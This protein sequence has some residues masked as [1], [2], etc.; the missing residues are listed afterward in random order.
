MSTEHVIENPEVDELGSAGPKRRIKKKGARHSLGWEILDNENIKAEDGWEAQRENYWTSKICKKY[1]KMYHIGKLWPR[2]CHESH[3]KAFACKPWMCKNDHF[4]HRAE[5]VWQALFGNRPKSKGYFNYILLSMVYSEVV[6]ER[7]VDWT[8]FQTTAEFPLRIGRNQ[9]HIPDLFDPDSVLTKTMLEELKKVPRRVRA[10]DTVSKEEARTEDGGNHVATK[11]VSREQSPARDLGGC[12]LSEHSVEEANAVL[13]EGGGVDNV[14]DKIESTMIPVDSVVS[15]PPTS[16]NLE[17]KAK[18]VGPST[19]MGTA[20]E[21]KSTERTSPVAPE[22]LFHGVPSNDRLKEMLKFSVQ[23]AEFCKN[24]DRGD[25]ES[26]VKYKLHD[27]K[28]IYSIACE[29]KHGAEVLA[30]MA[31]HFVEMAHTF[32]MIMPRVLHAAIGFE[33]MADQIHPLLKERIADNILISESTAT[34]EKHKKLIGELIVELQQCQNTGV[35]TIN[36]SRRMEE[37]VAVL[38]EMDVVA[39]DNGT[40]T[41][42]DLLFSKYEENNNEDAIPMKATRTSKPFSGE[43]H[44]D[45]GSSQVR[46]EAR[47]KGKAIEQLGDDT[48][49]L[50]QKLEVANKERDEARLELEALRRT[51]TTVDYTP[52]HENTMPWLGWVHRLQDRETMVSKAQYD[53]KKIA[54]KSQEACELVDTSLERFK[55]F[56][57]VRGY[58]ATNVTI[59]GDVVGMMDRTNHVRKEKEGDI[60]WAL[61]VEE[62]WVPYNTFSSNLVE[63]ERRVISTCDP[64]PAFLNDKCSMCQNHFGPE[65][66][67]TLGQCGHNFHSTC[68]SASSMTQSVCPLCR[69]PISTRFYEVMGMRDVMPPGHEFNRWNLPL[70]QLPKKFQNFRDWGKPLIWNSVFNCHQLYEEYGMERDRFFWMTRDYE[71]EIRAREIEDGEQQELF[72]RNFGGHWSTEH[73]RFFRFPPKRIE[74]REDGTWHEVEDGIRLGDEYKKYNCTPVGRA[75]VLAKLEEAA[76]LRVSTK[77]DSFEDVECSYWDASQAFDRR[78]GDVI[79]YWRNVLEKPEGELLVSFEDND[80]FVKKVVER[81]EKAMAI[82]AEKKVDPGG[83]RKRDDGNDSNDSWGLELHSE[84]AAVDREY[85]E[86]GRIARA[87]QRPRTRSR[88]QTVDTNEASSSRQ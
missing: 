28:E 13:E 29:M 44:V 41:S 23:M 58:E 82:F 73:K 47:E 60:D 1:V 62:G 16:I 10:V 8:T 5:E 2:D 61:E 12:G 19:S 55:N 66:A 3:T 22:A 79:G 45:V 74:K 32:Q 59:W 51:L 34:N 14:I 35:P 20:S 76:K 15:N 33:T 36:Y 86:G 54:A 30:D 72:C 6:L 63:S 68:I 53:L 4:L 85:E 18:D 77:E 65:G 11:P 24:L 9:K 88:A 69:S 81:I 37:A 52:S 87:S 71:V 50:L 42:D 43:L 49:S 40:E 57:G 83:K 39:V 26:L 21:P 27:D 38:H 78:I 64:A 17:P 56:V 70:D 7:K 75:L 46:L 67:Y 31:P 84:I 80:A 48:K 25:G